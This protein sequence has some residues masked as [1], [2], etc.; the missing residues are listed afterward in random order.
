M[1]KILTQLKNKI[2]AETNRNVFSE[3]KLSDVISKDDEIINEITDL[4]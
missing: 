2:F 1:S 4:F 3:I